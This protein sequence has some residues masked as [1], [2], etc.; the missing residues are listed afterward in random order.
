[1]VDSMRVI[2]GSEFSGGDGPIWFEFE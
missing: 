1:M 2:D